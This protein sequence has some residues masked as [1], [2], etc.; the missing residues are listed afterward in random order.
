MSY[1]AKLHF[2]RVT[3]LIA[4]CASLLAILNGHGWGVF[5]AAIFGY[6]AGS[7]RAIEII[8]AN[9]EAGTADTSK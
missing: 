8:E 1:K 2:M 9:E 5:P 7:L 6:A 4:G 3:G